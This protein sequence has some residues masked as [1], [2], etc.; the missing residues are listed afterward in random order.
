[1]IGVA[2]HAAERDVAAEF[3]ELFKTPWEFYRSDGRYDAVICN[4]DDFRYH[5][6]ALVFIFAGTSTSFDSEQR[7]Q[8]KSR[9]GGFVVSDEGKRLPIYGTLATFP[10]VRSSLLKEEGTQEAVAFSSDCGETT[11]LRVGYNLFEEIRFLLTTGQP[12]ANAGIP[13]LEEHAAWLRNW[14][15]LAGI[16]SVE[17]PPIPDGYSFMACLTHDIDHPA[18]RNHWFDHTMFGFL[19]RA[20]IATGLSVSRGRKPPRNLWLNLRAAFLL[21]FVHLGW[22]RDYWGDFDRYLEME[23]GNHSTFFVIPRKDYAGR[24]ANGLCPP[25]RACR[26]DLDQL[27]PQ[28]KKIVAADSE[29]GVHG[30]DAWVDADA[31]RDE[32]EK[33]AQCIGQS[34]LGVRMHWLCFDE[35]SPAKLDRAGFTYDST[36]GYRETVG[37]RSGTIQV[38]K[39]PGVKRLLELPLHIMDTAL[40]YPAYLNLPED[41]A[42]HMVRS[43]MNDAER[44]GGTLTIN[45]HDRSISPERLWDSFYLDLIKE[46]MRRNAWLPTAAR[47]VA[48]FRKRRSA[49]IE[50]GPMNANAVNVRV[51][52]DSTD[53]LP[54]L[55][56]RLHKPR[57][58]SLNDPVTARR[59]AAFADVSFDRSTEV[60]ITV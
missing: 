25:M 11:A 28:L 57:G 58:K 6:P 49:V 55:K 59:T 43:L 51:Q 52:L 22:A 41:G 40:F 19:Y 17:I 18:L 39:P 14:L 27:L 34:E 50:T 32:R 60:T 54:G 9:P 5:G 45:W 44:L 30:L 38:Y 8:V 29:V 42:R 3:F 36:V 10:G 47:A 46:L 24:T 48:W 15:T 13:T 23:T 21:P 12:A 33:V 4:V 2:V 56:I 1:M 26:Y 35:N 53:S 7:I 31:G 16:C 37:Y 20:T